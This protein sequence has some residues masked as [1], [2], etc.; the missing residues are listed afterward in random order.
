MATNDP[1]CRPPD[2]RVAAGAQGG[3]GAA[4]DDSTAVFVTLCDDALQQCRVFDCADVSITW[5]TTQSIDDCNA[6]VEAWRDE[7]GT[8]PLEKT[9]GPKF[10]FWACPRD[11]S[12]S[13]PCE[14]CYRGCF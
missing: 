11:N 7:C 9:F 3:N 13:L 4:D 10:S 14:N 12:G 6:V 8:H 2:D 5:E 1:L